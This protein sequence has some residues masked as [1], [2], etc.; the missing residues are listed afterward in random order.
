QLNAKIH[1]KK[2]EQ[3]VEVHHVKFSF[4]TPE[5]VEHDSDDDEK[6]S[7]NGEE[8]EIDDE[9]ES[10]NSEKDEVD[11]EEEPDKDDE[12]EDDKDS[13]DDKYEEQKKEDDLD[14]KKKDEKES[15]K[16]EKKTKGKYKDGSYKLPFKVLK[17]DKDDISTTEQYIKN[18][19]KVIIKG[20]VYKVRMTLT[21]R[22]ST[23][24]NS[25]HV[26]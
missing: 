9:K 19:A 12:V 14:N 7:D 22:K 13:D 8:D 25:S 17:E 1:I 18:P 16:K 5:K 21:D 11:D 20:D 10:D 4:K 6:E 15:S 26:S 24:L 2:P 23:R 3:E